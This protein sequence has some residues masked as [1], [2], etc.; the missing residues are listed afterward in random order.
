MLRLTAC[1]LSVLVSG[2]AASVVALQPAPQL[3]PAPPPP[4]RVEAAA[5]APEPADA[6]SPT[7]PRVVT[8][9]ASV[10]RPAAAAEPMIPDGPSPGEDEAAAAAAAE[11]AAEAA[12]D[13]ELDEPSEDEGEDHAAQG[14]N[15][16]G[17]LY[18]AEL[19]DA[20]LK[21][22]WAT[23]PEQLGSISLGF[24]DE[25]RVI[26]AVQ[27][28]KGEGWTVVQPAKAWATQETVDAVITAIR[29]LKAQYPD[30]HPLRVNQLS[31]PEGGF[32]R[33]HKSHQNGR[34]VDLAFYYPTAEP[35]RVRE[36]ERYIDVP[37]N[38]ALLKALIIHTDV[39]MVLVD[40]RVIKVLYDHALSVGEDREWLDS[41]F[42]AGR[43]SLVKHARRHRDHF[44]VRFYNGRAQEL[45]RRVAP[46][47]AL[48]PEQNVRMHKV[49]RGDTLGAIAARYGSTVAAIRKANRMNST[50]LRVA[51]VLKVPL[52]G[53]CTRCP[54]PPPVVVPERRLPPPR[55]EASLQKA[56][57]P[58]VT[59]SVQAAPN[60]PAA[61]F[62]ALLGTVGGSL[63]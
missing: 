37:K 43:Q 34:D 5:P 20:E 1:L 21:E 54:I 19:S 39:Q 13:D 35:I 25:G 63:P 23:A 49:R 8:A 38:W 48:R 52:R 29:A 42:R 15:A 50:F 16:E 11:A 10:S 4:E 61:R 24:V 53:P 18:S 51:Q 41:I 58:V 9:S 46:L 57:A 31:G 47:L 33:P 6:P 26:N 60:K 14:P 36:R 45:G 7:E 44:H 40:R 32:L 17:H 59:A 22:L 2:C 56:S 27:F 3:E 12:D 55:L 62:P 28:P 30:A